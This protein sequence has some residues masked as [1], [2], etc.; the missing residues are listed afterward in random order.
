M[1]K[2]FAAILFL[3]SLVAAGL[4]CPATTTETVSLSYGNKIGNLAYDFSVPDLTGEIVTLS[5]LKGRPVLINFWST[6]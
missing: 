4:G 2:K 3:I 6:G 5:E 1:F